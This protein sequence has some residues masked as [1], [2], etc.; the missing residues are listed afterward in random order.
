MRARFTELLDAARASGEAV[1]AFSCH[2]LVQAQGVLEAAE[3]RGRSVIILVPRQVLSSATI[4]AF[5]AVADASS[6][7]ACLQLDHLGDLEAVQLGLESGAAAVMVDGAR[8][9][10]AE[11]TRFVTAAVELARRFG[12]EVECELRSVDE[13]GSPT[14]PERAGGSILASGASCFAAAIGNAH[15]HYRQE[16]MLDMALLARIKAETGD[17]FLSLHGCSGIPGNQLRAAIAGGVAK[18]NVNTELRDRYLQTMQAVGVSLGEP[19]YPRDGL[20]TVNGR[21]REA[22]RSAAE[23][24]YARLEP[25]APD[26]GMR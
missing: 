22:M 19:P 20:A 12:G 9:P 24:V 8:L 25:P 6:V 15:G 17:R 11:S 23:A 4:A 10:A 21:L 5:T 16:P 1:V 3:H 26:E 14:D 18:V 2:D 13:E 7:P